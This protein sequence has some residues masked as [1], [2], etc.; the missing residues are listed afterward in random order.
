[1]SDARIAEVRAQWVLDSRGNPTVRVGIATTAGHR[2][3]AMVPSGASTGEHEA[4]ELRDGDRHRFGGKGVDRVVENVEGPLAG[5]VRG[6]PVADQEAVDR[7]LL[8]ADGTPNKQRLGA[9][10]ILG[11]SLAVARARAASLEVPLY[12]SLGEGFG[13]PL[14]PVPLLNVVNGGAHADNNVDVQEFMLVPA[15]FPSFA[16]SLRAGAET[17]QALKAVLR[18]RG[19]ATAVGDEGGFAP[20]LA[21]NEAALELLLEAVGRAGYRAG[22]EIALALDV[23]ANELARD[24]GYRLGAGGAV[25]AGD[26][27]V[28]LYRG[29]AERFPLL[30]IEDGLAEDDWDGWAA[31]TRG[32][33][34]RLQL[35]GDDLFV[36]NRIRLERGLALGAANA[37]LIKP[38]QIGSLTETLET[39]R[40]AR[41][42]G[43]RYI[44]SHRSGETE[45]PFIADLAVA[46]GAGQIKTGA[47]CRAERTAK[48]NRLLE[49]EAELGS[50]SAYAG[51]A[52][53]AR[54]VSAADVGQS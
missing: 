40:L 21:S 7:R 3:W 19:L 15:G 17:Y 8:E 48:Y 12:R 30:S 47:P 20:D 45:D 10:A 28:D 9:N 32:L 52:A 6:L 11:V 43:Y 26:A 49:I 25:L 39:I 16:E 27:V 44:I 38:N 51:S 5:A 33:G 18:E 4:L 2:G 22:E 46:T 31:L 42:G 29:W 24:G 53:F 34:E 37:I 41:Q 54:G 13:E 36:T 1:V 23:A 50:G 14:L 35:V